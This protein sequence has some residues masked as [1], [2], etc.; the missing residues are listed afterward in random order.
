[1][2]RALALLTLILAFAV[3]AVAE[4]T[5]EAEAKPNNSPPPPCTDAAHRQFDFWVG[6]WS[7]T[8]P[9]GGVAGENSI[10]PILNGCVLLEQWQGASGS[11]GKSFN[12]YDARQGVWR[13][14]WVDGSGGR[15][16]LT[17]GL[18]GN[19]MVLSGE[20]PGRDGGTVTHEIRWTPQE[21]GTVR[22]HWK[23]SK[24]GGETWNDLFVGIYS[25]RLGSG[26]VSEDSGLSDD[27]REAV[28][29]ADLSYAEAWLAN[30]ADSIMATL[31]QDAVII[32]SGMDAIEGQEAIRTFWFP[33]DSRA[34]TVNEY[35]LD[36][37]EVNGSADLAYVRG[38][39][40]LAF[41]YD[42]DS[43]ESE[44]TYLS[45]LR[46]AEDGRWR[47]ARRTWNDHQRN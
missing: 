45:L 17:G 9:D 44:G 22:Q 4:D 46:R 19:D 37:A 18:D 2:T 8:Q 43:Y 25:Q 29:A 31:T 21:D 38:S 23:A 26:V 40:T 1:M 34:A 14:T 27:D 36:Q 12:M 28:A 30:D 35:R 7:V 10:Q 41:D 33:P 6:E 5:G 32:P 3:T 24:D 20:Q 42:G 13:Q 39:F 16:D 11:T 47:I 15:L